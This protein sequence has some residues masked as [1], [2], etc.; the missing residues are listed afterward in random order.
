MPQRGECLVLSRRRARELTDVFAG[1]ARRDLTQIKRATVAPG[2]EAAGDAA[3]GPAGV[4]VIESRL[5]KFFGGEGG[6][7]SLTQDDDRRSRAPAAVLTC[8][9]GGITTSSLDAALSAIY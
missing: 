4:F 1:Q 5:E 8:R 6:V 3:V 7:G 9:T 2:K